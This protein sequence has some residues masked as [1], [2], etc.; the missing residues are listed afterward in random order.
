MKNHEIVETNPFLIDLNPPF[1]EI[2]DPPLHKD[3]FFLLSTKSKDKFYYFFLS[4]LC[5]TQT[6]L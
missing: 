5:S 1:I 4:V 3:I 6:V 2:L